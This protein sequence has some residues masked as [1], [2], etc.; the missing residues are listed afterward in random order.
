MRAGLFCGVMSGTSLDGIDAA[1]IRFSRGAARIVA[2]ARGRFRPA[3]RR[4]LLALCEKGDDEI[5]RAQLAANEVARAYAVVVVDLARRAPGQIIAVGAHGQ[6]IRHRPRAGFSTQLLNGALLAELTGI[7]VVCDFRARDIAARGQGAPLACGFHQFAFA[8]LA[9]C[10]VV[11]IGGVANAT[12]LR[13]DEPARG[14]DVG[15]GN[16]LMDA[17]NQKHK[18]TPFDRGGEW[19]RQARPSSRLLRQ[20]LESD[21]ARRFLR[22]RAPKSCGRE[23]FDISRFEPILRGEDA[24]VAQATLLEFTAATI[25]A[26]IRKT[27]T[28]LVI[29]CGGG[30]KNDALVARLRDLARPARVCAS[31]EVGIAAEH[32]EAAAFAYLAQRR[33]LRLPANTPSATGARGERILGALHCGK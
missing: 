1:L 12:I 2:V 11:N 16:M 33:I 3:L 30:A 13:P 7:D 18:N 21:G 27:K 28:P 29:L 23:E 20:L 14:W 6:T 4:E 10:A 32:I 15:P 19:A 25:A 31:D 8:R 17:W 5:E 22:R 26:E 9:P 24:G